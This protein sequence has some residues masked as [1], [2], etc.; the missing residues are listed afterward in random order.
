MIRSR[1]DKWLSIGLIAP[2]FVAVMVF[3]YGFIGWSFRVAF[4]KWDGII[5]NFAFAGFRNFVYI[6][7]NPRFQIDLWNNLFF[8][9]LFMFVC[10]FFGLLLAVVLDRKVNGEGVYRT[11]YLFPMA[12]SFIVTGVAWRWILNPSA[13]INILLDSMGLSSLKW[14]W[15]IDTRS[16]GPFHLALIPI[17]LAAAWQFTGYIMAMFLAGI[18]GIPDELIEA[19]RMDGAV[20]LTIL[21]KVILPILRPITLSALIVLAH[22]SLKIF[23]LVYSMTGPGPSFV[24]DVPGLYMFQTTFRGNHYSEGAAVSV[25]ML[26]MV[27]VV[28]VPYLLSTLRKDVPH[29]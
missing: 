27:A 1:K 22:V 3:V 12:I 11:I 17:V 2:S 15:Y 29:E 23:D 16:I 28:I 5:P 26:L 9:L 14:L 6:F 21:R 7:R 24:T 18:R 4:S 19:A 20:E 25:V 10:W 8:T 13:G